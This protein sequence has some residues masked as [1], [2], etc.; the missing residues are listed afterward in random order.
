M[1]LPTHPGG[2][3]STAVGDP[4]LLL[5]AVSYHR[6]VEA[7][8]S[9]SFLCSCRTQVPTPPPLHVATFGLTA[10]RFAASCRRST[11]NCCLMAAFALRPLAVCKQCFAICCYAGRPQLS[12]CFLFWKKEHGN[13]W[14]K[15]TGVG[16]DVSGRGKRTTALWSVVRLTVTV[17]PPFL[18]RGTDPRRM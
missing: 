13:K 18:F 16:D 8:F 17:G 2:E 3:A 11:A 12:F 9:F 4:Q 6:P 5:T 10:D 1:R 7:L 14:T 15:A